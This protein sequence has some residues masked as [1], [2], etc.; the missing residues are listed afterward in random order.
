MLAIITGDIV[1]SRKLISQHDWLIPLE[2]VLNAWGSKTDTW[3]IFRGDS[4]QVEV[5]DP[6]EALKKAII[7]KATLKSIKVL[8][9][10]KRAAPIDVRMSIG[11]G[12]MEQDAESIGMRTGSAYFFSGEAFE[13]LRAKDQNL[14]V[15]SAW[16]DFDME[17]NLMLKLA[18]IVMDNWTSNSGEIVKITLENPYLKQTEIGEI[19]GIEQNSVSARLQR[20]YV[21]VLMEMERLYRL[22]LSKLMI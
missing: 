16:E 7:I 5:K 21:E 3:E 11:I 1:D 15:K 2:S 14:L 6:L 10:Q 19:L 9:S 20:S 22:K 17:L 18:L 8:D 12:D 4:F 13:Q